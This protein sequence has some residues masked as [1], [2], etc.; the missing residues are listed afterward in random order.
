MRTSIASAF[1]R[2]SVPAGLDERPDEKA[3]TRP[4]RV[5]RLPWR[6]QTCRGR[7][8]LRPRTSNVQRRTSNFERKKRTEN[9]T[10]PYSPT[11][12]VPWIVTLVATASFAAPAAGLEPRQR[13]LKIAHGASRGESGALAQESPGRGAGSGPP[14]TTSAAELTDDQRA[15][16][17]RPFRHPCRGSGAA[18][19]V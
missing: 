17:R 6:R 3:D 15:R 5:H 13:R 14:S 4:P 12:L 1:A 11:R 8:R 2:A 16:A 18:P 7:P 10:L 9:S 19:R